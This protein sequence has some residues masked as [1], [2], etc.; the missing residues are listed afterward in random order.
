MSFTCPRCERTS[1]NPTDAAEGYCGHCHDWTATGH[2]VKVRLY[3]GAGEHRWLW[4]ETRIDAHGGQ[5]VEQLAALHAAVVRAAG[6]GP[7]PLPYT[8]EFEFWDGDVT[9][10]GTD[11]AALVDFNSSDGPDALVVM[12]ERKMRRPRDN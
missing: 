4:E 3:L 12:L 6:I 7:V 8:V 1:H 2:W 10:F 5:P 9:S 11:P